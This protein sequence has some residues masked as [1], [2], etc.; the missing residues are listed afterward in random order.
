MTTTLWRLISS[1][2]IEALQNL[3]SHDPSV[4]N[5]RAAD[6]RGPL[7]WAYE[8]SVDEAIEV[9]ESFGADPSATDKD[10]KTPVQLKGTSKPF[11]R[12][13]PIEYEDD[14]DEDDE[15]EDEQED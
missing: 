3:I 6:G 15:D 10:G 13:P 12:P 2:E 7:F 8:F 5:L 9:L 1:K 4:V 14:E 11:V